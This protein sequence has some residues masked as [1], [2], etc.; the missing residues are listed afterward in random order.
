[1]PKI[2]HF[3]F[4]ALITTIN[5]LMESKQDDKDDEDFIG[6]QQ[7]C[8]AVIEMFMG[9]AFWDKINALTDYSMMEFEPDNRDKLMMIGF[10]VWKACVWC[11]N[12]T[13]MIAGD[14][15]NQTAESYACDFEQFLLMFEATEE[16]SIETRH[17][18]I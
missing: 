4:K 2:E 6:R 3:E 15:E 1:M 11:R 7:N 12:F 17:V 16:I 13:S 10:E 18:M 14:S 8:M 9:S 5:R